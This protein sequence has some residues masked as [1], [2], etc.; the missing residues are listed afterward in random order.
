[1]NKNLSEKSTSLSGYKRMKPKS[2][3][4]SLAKYWKD[5]YTSK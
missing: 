1:M 5:S 3:M 2:N 4:L